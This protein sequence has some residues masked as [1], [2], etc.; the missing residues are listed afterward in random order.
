MKELVEFLVRELTDSNDVTVE[1]VNGK[2]ITEIIVSAGK[3]DIGK[4]IGKQGRI[5]KA[6]RTI[7]KAASYHEKKKYTVSIVEK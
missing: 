2:G 4:I 3:D 7:V 6:I 1:M 5:S